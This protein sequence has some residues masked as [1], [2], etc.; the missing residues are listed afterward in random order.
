MTDHADDIGHV[1]D[2][3]QNECEPE[4]TSRTGQRSDATSLRQQKPTEFRQS[5]QSSERLLLAISRVQSLFIDE[6]EPDSVYD[7]M[8]QE[9]LRLT[10]SEYGCIG[11]VSR[12]TDQKPYLRTYA[13]TDPARSEDS[14]ALLDQQSANPERTNLKA[15]CGQVMTTG[16]PFIVN[17]P[18]ASGFLLGHSSVHALMGLPIYRGKQLIGVIG[19]AN[20]SGGY[21]EAGITYLNHS[22]PHVRNYWKASVTVGLERKPKTRCV[23]ARIGSGPLYRERTKASGIGISQPTKPTFRLGGKRFL[24]MKTTNFLMPIR[25]GNLVY[26]QKIVI[27]FCPTCPTT[28]RGEQNG[29]TSSFAFAERMEAI[30]GS[31]PVE[32]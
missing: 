16:Q 19:I 9:I 20:R 32:S 17:D 30:A 8:L 27:E 3:D 14:K 4:E 18:T 25:N 29:T 23:K 13:I 21:D 2:R 26:T 7:V 15:L 31:M 11:E 28:L 6:A 5:E 24:A 1:T 22:C 12:D 10:G